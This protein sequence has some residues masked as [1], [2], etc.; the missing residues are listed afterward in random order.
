MATKGPKSTLWVP[1]N[2]INAL[3]GVNVTASEQTTLPYELSGGQNVFT[4]MFG[5][6]YGR[7]GSKVLGGPFSLSGDQGGWVFRTNEGQVVPISVAHGV[8]YY[9]DGTSYVP[10]PSS[11]TLSTSA[12]V[13]GI[14]YPEQ[15]KFYLTDGVSDIVEIAYGAP[16][17][18]TST[19]GLPKCL[20]L[21]HYNNCLVYMALSGAL[22]QYVLS[23]VGVTTVVNPSLQAI[24]CNGT[25]L[26]MANLDAY[27]AVV[28]TDQMAY[29]D[30]GLQFQFDGAGN[31]YPFPAVHSEIYPSRCVAPRSIL[32]VNGVAYWAGLDAF[33]NAEFY[34]CD[35]QQV[36]PVGWS[37]IK[38]YL[39]DLNMSALSGACAVQYGMYYKVAVPSA[40]SA[41]NDTELL[42]DTARSVAATETGVYG[43]PKVVWEPKHVPGYY[44]GQYATWH[45]GGQDYVLAFDPTEGV[46]RYQG[47]GTYDEVPFVSTFPTPGSSPSYSTITIT[48]SEEISQP[49]PTTYSV[50]VN[51]TALDIS[52]Y[53]GSSGAIGVSVQAD[54]GS[55][56]PSGVPLASGSYAL[57]GT[58]AKVIYVPYSSPAYL[59]ANQTYHLVVSVTGGNLALVSRTDTVY[60][61]GYLFYNGSSW[62]LQAAASPV[63]Q[64]YYQGEIDA[65]AIWT[66]A[67]ER[68]LDKKKLSRLLV[69]GISES[70][71]TIQMG[72][73]D[74]G[75]EGTF[76]DVP[77][78]LQG[79]QTVWAEASSPPSVGYP[80]TYESVYT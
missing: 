3:G 2:P 39:R 57:T 17:T 1:E 4:D 9:Y 71:V 49:F 78:T 10:I 21:G 29:R 65:S 46:A 25:V 60:N 23:S 48:P 58:I 24:V 15:D 22:N 72:I 28:V 74:Q 19:T 16:P 40:G 75:R 73:S 68:P 7:S 42:L 27:S 50:G 8:I 63:F 54:N 36:F 31:E 59:Q 41:F 45:T 35:G 66:T 26:G 56:L 64:E 69:N 44:I 47:I 70:G 18:A 5:A 51:G 32:T 6:F 13:N 20:Y 76:S 30:S 80:A 37:K 61:G 12:E 34:R 11:P 52:S 38:T 53:S 79:A 67:M 77:F 55:G 62:T 33:N 43:P 14:F